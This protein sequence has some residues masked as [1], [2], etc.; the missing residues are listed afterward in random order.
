MRAGPLSNKEIVELLNSRFIP[1]YAVNEDYRDS[2]KPPEEKAVYNRLFR[3]AGAKNLSAG[4]VH[5]YILSPDGEVVDSLHVA[6]GA[7]A[8]VLKAALQKNAARFA[9]TPGQ[10]IVS[11]RPQAAPPPCAEGS[12]QLHLVV[13]SLDGKGVW[14]ELPGEDWITLLPPEVRDLIPEPGASTFPVPE[15][16]A[17]KI[18]R[19]F[20]P[21][22][23]NNDVTKNKFD[24]LRLTA[25]VL[26]RSSSIVRLRL[27]GDF[28]ME[29]SF[30]HK[31]DGKKVRASVTGYY[32]YDPRTDKITSLNMATEHATYNGGT[33]GAGLRSVP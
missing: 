31:P 6:E 4:T 30:Y 11:P 8:S 10:P 3:D 5:V 16:T 22:T 14:T 29:H 12:L 33:F 28:V 17:K 1:V 26:E 15:S 32:D 13:R 21:A 27:D 25:T 24:Q 20:Y 23:E 18:L 2:T 7:K 19:H 9:V